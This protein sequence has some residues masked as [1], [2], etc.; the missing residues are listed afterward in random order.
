MSDPFKKYDRFT[1]RELYWHLHY[2]QM[3]EPMIDQTIKAVKEY[4]RERANA[5]ARLRERE[6]QWGELFRSLQHERKIVRA[7]MRYKPKTPTP[8]R[9]SFL[10]AYYDALTTLFDKM[11]A[12]KLLTQALP[13]HSHWTDYVPEHIKEAFRVESGA[14]PPRQKAKH[15]EPFVKEDPTKLRDLRFGRL[16]RHIDKELASTTALLEADPNNERYIRKESLL[17]QARKRTRALGIR[18]HVPNHWKDMVQDLMQDDA[19]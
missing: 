15:K 7:M 17:I 3:P 18:D 5:K 16:M 4:R 9:D 12:K 11:T 1:Y 14:I 6:K 13:P 2:R 8:E 19:E 10:S